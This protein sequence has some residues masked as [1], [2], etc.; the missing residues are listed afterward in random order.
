[1]YNT[2]AFER[3]AIKINGDGVCA[4]CDARALCE[5]AQVS[6]KAKGKPFGSN[7]FYKACASTGPGDGVHVLK[8]K[9]TD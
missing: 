5:D 3:V 2:Y 8:R 6:T 1:M 7:P 9:G 4:Q